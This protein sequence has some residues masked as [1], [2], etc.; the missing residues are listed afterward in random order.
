MGTVFTIMVILGVI[1]IFIWLFYKIHS[2][3]KVDT[4]AVEEHAKEVKKDTLVQRTKTV[5]S[6]ISKQKKN[7]LKGLR[8]NAIA[9]SYAK[10]ALKDRPIRTFGGF[11]KIKPF[12]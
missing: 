5:S 11:S 6:V 4:G 8:D 1:G 3:D 9:R 10:M 2:K 12:K 7:H